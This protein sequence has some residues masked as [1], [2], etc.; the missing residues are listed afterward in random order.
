MKTN[1]IIVLLWLDLG[2]TVK[3]S[4]WQFPWP[5]PS[6][7]P[8]DKG[9]YLT[10]YPSSYHNTHYT[11]LGRLQYS[12]LY[13]RENV[14]SDWLEEQKG[15]ISSGWF[16]GSRSKR[17]C[18]NSN[19]WTRKLGVSPGNLYVLSQIWDR[20]G[21]LKYEIFNVDLEEHLAPEWGNLSRQNSHRH[22]L[23]WQELIC[24]CIVR[25]SKFPFK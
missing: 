11:E 21:F 4:P 24:T 10:V 5:L 19:F 25:F 16:T 18:I 23:L 12:I 22:G 9:R 20:I 3:Y 8:W 2:Y 13:S 1:Y 17:L 7:T 15:A 6:G 14:E